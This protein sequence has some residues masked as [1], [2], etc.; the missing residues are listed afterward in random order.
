MNNTEKLKEIQKLEGLS[1]DELLQELRTREGKARKRMRAM[2]IKLNENLRE[3]DDA[4]I[5]EVLKK[6]NKKAIYGTDDRKDI[7]QLPT[8]SD[9]DDADSVVALF[10][11]SKVINNGD[12][13]S[14]LQTQ[15]FGVAK[16]LC[17]NEHFR[18][19][20]IGAFCSGFLVAPDIIATAGHCVSAG[21]VTNIRFVF[22][23]RMRDESAAETVIKNTEIYS[24]IAIIGRQ[25]VE[26]GPD[27]SLVR[28]DR[29]VTNHRIA[30]IRRSGRVGD[31]SFTRDRTPCWPADKICGWSGDSQQSARRI[32]CGQPRHLIRR[33]FR[34][35]SFQQR[36]SRS[37]R[38]SCTG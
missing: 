20:P 30:R 1:V 12:G 27:W 33:Q 8:G 18:G 32:F 36:Y 34:V 16:N 35:T 26:S 14:T 13:A 9:L 28:I 6:Q 7:Y 19:Q 24:G 29:P 17:T 37:G 3:F 25:E 2:P 5:G 21:D 15:N 10:T 31:T 22:G 4:T 11:S 23:F 38:N